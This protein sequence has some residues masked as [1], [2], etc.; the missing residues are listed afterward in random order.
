MPSSSHPNHIVDNIIYTMAFRLLRICSD[1][2]TL[3]LRLEELKSDF[4][5]P[6]KYNTRKIEAVF[7]KIRN[8][9]RIGTANSALLTS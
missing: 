9:D 2:E 1:S 8:L 5:V 4:L 7:D 6:R 3:N